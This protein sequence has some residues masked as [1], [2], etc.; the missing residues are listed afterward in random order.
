MKTKTLQHAF[1]IVAAAIGNRFGIKVSVGGDQAYTDGKAIQL[2]AYAGDDPAYQAVAWGLLAHEAAHIRYS[3]FSIAYGPSVL[4]RRLAGAIEDV[5]IEHELAKDYPGTRLTLRTVIENMI[6]KG[7]F[8]AASAEDHPANILVGYVLK[9]LRARVLGQVALQ[10]LVDQ[11]EIAL[12]ATFP[13]GAV[14]RCKACCQKC[15][16]DSGRNR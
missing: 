2:P 4:R 6:E 9:S 13:K 16:R 1:P 10:P 5:R 12:K 3:D 14:I 15:P 7:G 11:T 8:S